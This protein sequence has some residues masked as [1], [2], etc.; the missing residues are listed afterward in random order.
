MNIPTRNPKMLNATQLQRVKEMKR[1]AETKLSNIE[2]NLEHLRKQQE[3]LRRYN[4]LK[5]ALNQEKTRLFELNKQQA[6]MAEDIRQLERYETFE[7]I[8]GTFQRIT[9]LEKLTDQNKRSLSVLDRESSSLRQTWSEQEKLQTQMEGQRKSAEE[10]YYGIHDYIFHAFTLEGSNRA[11]EEEID[12]LNKLSEIANQ[13]Y[14]AIKSNTAEVE[15]VINF[16]SEELARHKAKRQGME[17]HEQMI[18]HAEKILLLLDNLQEI[19]E[20]QQKTKNLQADTLQKQDEENKLLE[21][22]FSKYQE[23]TSEIETLESELQTHRANILGLDSYKLQERAMQLKSLKQML[24]SAQSLWHQISVGYNSIEEK[25]KTLNELRLHIENTERNIREMETEVGKLSRLCH[26]KEHTY[27]LSKGQNIIQLR[28]DLKEGISC[29]VCGATHH[30]YHS[31]TM[32]DQSKLISEFKTDYELLSAEL[33]GKRHQLDDLRLD[34]AESKGRQFSEERSLN[35]IR[36]RQ[37]SNIKEWDIY[38]SLDTSFKE[39]TASTNQNARM[40]LIRHM[41]E[42][43][44]S[45]A[46]KAQKELDTFNYHMSQITRLGEKLQA[47]EL[48][49][50]DLSVQLNEVNTGCQVMVGQVERVL[51]MIDNESIRFS[52]VYHHLE[53]CIT[54]KDWKGIWDKNHEGLREQIIKL[55]STWNNTNEQILKEEQELALCKTRHE[56]YLLQQKNFKH[57]LELVK[58]RTEERGNRIE[59]NNKAIRQATGESGPKKLYEETY[60]QMGNARQAEENEQEKSIKILHDI[61]Y[62][63]GRDEFHISFGKELAEKLSE[64]RSRLDLWMSNYNMHHPP[65]QYSELQKVFNEANDWESIRSHIQKIQK[66]IAVCQARVDDLNSRFIALQAEDNYH[67]TDNDTIQESLAAQQENLERKRRE[68]MMQIARQTVALEE[69][70]KAVHSINNS[71]LYQMTEQEQ[72]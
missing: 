28:S 70:E 61:D 9:I 65:V 36:L 34:L 72:S 32:L 2:E 52:E 15:Q 49:K 14:I 60:R 68:I 22:V 63:K 8:Q 19:E 31:D 50:K 27:L 44:Q 30:P 6:S 1:L 4:S 18:L 38:S 56:F 40:A 33:R 26:E 62:L 17:M 13:Q 21:R 43:T 59:E 12:N 20:Q 29:S 37:N 64:E 67:S 24:V 10:R 51:S 71:A 41:L 3:Y 48:Q 55:K 35:D 11:C 7:S 47:L 45:D 46:E 42:N 53:E 39:C 5:M 58:N 25:V 16:L 23:V 69:H 57:Y 54:I 66:D